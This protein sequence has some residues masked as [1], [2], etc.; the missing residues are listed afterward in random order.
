M[1]VKKDGD[2]LVATETKVIETKITLDELKQRKQMFQNE[3]AELQRRI[4]EVNVR[5]AENQ[6][7]ID[8]CKELKIVSKQEAEM[9]AMIAEQEK[10]LAKLKETVK[11]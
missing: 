7:L 8:K 4:D 5:L 11:A 3:K 9:A 10:Q 2:Y 6:A 1:E